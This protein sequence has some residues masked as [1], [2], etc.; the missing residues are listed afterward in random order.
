MAQSS[1]IRQGVLSTVG[2]GVQGLARFGYSILIARFVGPDELATVNALIALSILL[3]LL[4]PTA[5][6]NAAGMQLARALRAHRSPGRVL[7]TVWGSSGIAVAIIGLVAAAVGVLTGA[8]SAGDA[9]ALVALTAAWSAYI[10]ARGVRMGLGQVGQAAAWDGITAAI[11]LGG[12]IAV[13]ALGWMEL[14]LLPLTLGYA[15]FALAA[16]PGMRRGHPRER[17]DL[18]I[19]ADVLRLIG[20]N[21]IGLLAA[22]GLLQFSM[23]F[24]EVTDTPREAGMFAAAIALA[25]PASMIAQ[26]ASQVLIPRYA[27]WLAEDPRHARDAHVRVMAVLGGGLFVVFGAVGVLADWIVAVLYGP[28]YE[29]SVPLLRILLIGVYLF[30]IGLL[31]TTFLITSWRALTATIAATIGTV[32]GVAFMALGAASLGG[33]MAAAIGVVVG[34]AITAVIAT[35]ASLPVPVP[36]AATAAHRRQRGRAERLG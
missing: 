28:G 23:V 3:S 11:S 26:A 7:A 25:T 1:L 22:N 9:V 31:A 30:S 13:I 6:G 16:I 29:D 8:M 34:T 4:W 24:A 17:D 33:A 12:L 2:V 19:P 27:H 32:V 36:P 5:A 35:V 18:T 10:L 14:L 15:V 21:S 20:W